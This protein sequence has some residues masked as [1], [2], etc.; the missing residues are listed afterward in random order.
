[1]KRLSVKL[2]PFEQT[3]R[4]WVA[5]TKKEYTCEEGPAEDSV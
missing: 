3:A 2:D 1:M 4:Y 5:R